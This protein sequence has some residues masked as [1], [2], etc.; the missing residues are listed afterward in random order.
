MPRI[1]PL[2]TCGF[3]LKGWRRVESETAATFIDGAVAMWM[4]WVTMTDKDGRT[5]RVDKSFGYTK[6]PDGVLRI[7]LHHSSLPYRP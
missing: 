4:G 2:I 5:T 1:L 7:V 6:D 3:A